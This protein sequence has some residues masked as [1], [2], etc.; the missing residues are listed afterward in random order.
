MLEFPLRAPSSQLSATQ[1]LFNDQAAM[2]RHKKWSRGGGSTSSSSS[3]PQTGGARGTRWGS[4]EDPWPPPP[5]PVAAL[6]QG[7]QRKAELSNSVVQPP[8]TA[9]HDRITAPYKGV[10]ALLP[11]DPN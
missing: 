2:I 9:R 5:P 8:S 6:L 7:V 1:S 10:G 11:P 3:G 4:Q